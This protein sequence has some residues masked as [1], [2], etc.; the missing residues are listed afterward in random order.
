MLRLWQAGNG[1]IPQWRLLLEDARTHDLHGFRD[2]A[3]LLVFLREQ[4]ENSGHVIEVQEIPQTNPDHAQGHTYVD[5]P[6]DCND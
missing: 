3:D 5:S 6:C 4:M 2:L 1:D